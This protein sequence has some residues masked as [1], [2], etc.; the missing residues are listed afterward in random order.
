MRPE[1]FFAPFIV[2]LIVVG[3]LCLAVGVASAGQRYCV[4]DRS[5]VEHPYFVPCKEVRYG[6]REV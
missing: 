1:R 3:L 6:E 4:G 5:T 2:V